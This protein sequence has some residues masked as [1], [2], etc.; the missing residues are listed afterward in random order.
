[1]T[2]ARPATRRSSRSCCASRPADAALPD[3]ATAA[4][5]GVQP[6]ARLQSRRAVPGH[7]ALAVYTFQRPAAGSLTLVARVLGI[8]TSCDE[9]S[10]AVV[11]GTGDDAGMRALVLLWKEGPAWLG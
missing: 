5:G 3:A 10:A 11:E 1:M 6:A 4:D 8:E 7:R 2:G 9:T